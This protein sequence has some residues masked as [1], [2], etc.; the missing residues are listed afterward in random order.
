V[1]GRLAERRGAWYASVADLR[2]DTSERT[3]E[4]VAAIVAVA[5]EAAR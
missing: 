3:P 2:V 4:E 1:L 5:V